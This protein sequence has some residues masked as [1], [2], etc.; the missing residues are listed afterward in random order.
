MLLGGHFI[1]SKRGSQDKSFLGDWKPAPN[2]A[3]PT[4][5][6]EP[7]GVSTSPGTESPLYRD[8]RRNSDNHHGYFLEAAG[9]ITV[10]QR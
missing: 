3:G 4:S 10:M 9:E 8:G 1:D 5:T 6:L 7:P 2:P